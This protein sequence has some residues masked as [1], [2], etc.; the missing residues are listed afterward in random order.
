MSVPGAGDEEDE[1]PRPFGT[2]GPALLRVAGWPIETVA[3]LRS[4]SLVARID[5]WID[6]DDAILQDG[7]GLSQRLHAL[8]PGIDGR[9]TRRSALALKRCLHGTTQPLSRRIVSVLLSD[10][11]VQSVIGPSIESASDR[12]NRHT[13]ER[14]AIEHAHA[15]ELARARHE[16]DRITSDDR[17]LRALCVASPS[18]FRQ[19]QRGQRESVDERSRRRLQGTAYRYLMRAVGRAT[20]NSLWAGVALED[21]SGSPRPVTVAR[22]APVTRVGPNLG[23]FA[24]A[25]EAMCRR[26]P[27][28]E[29]MI[30]AAQSD[31]TTREPRCLG[32]RNLR[33]G[34]LVCPA[35]F[36]PP[37]H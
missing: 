28:L 21:R 34:L 1:S 15:T 6:E 33:A 10:R 3:P 27:W 24:R 19:W 31:V 36:A 22:T 32:A 13:A 12:R 18:M 14:D 37:G 5:A 16:L 17:F 20:P 29:S 2:L 8:I 25:L 7:E 4:Q 9:E 35:A 30:V 23:V 11:R 26:R